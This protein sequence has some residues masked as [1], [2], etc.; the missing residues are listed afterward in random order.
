MLIFLRNFSAPL[1]HV[2]CNLQTKEIRVVLVDQLGM[3]DSNFDVF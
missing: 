1:C 2:A 3:F